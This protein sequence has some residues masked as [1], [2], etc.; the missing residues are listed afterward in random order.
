MARLVAIGAAVLFYL[1]A[2]CAVALADPAG[3]SPGGAAELARLNTEILRHPTDTALNLRY[4][5]LAEALGKPRLA[6]SAYERILVYEPQNAAAIA[7]VSRIRKGLQPNTTKYVL[8]L[9]AK[10]ESN[11]LLLPSSTPVK[12][13]GQFFGDL[14]VRDERRIGGFSWRTLADVDGIAHG[15]DTVLDYA[16]A[17]AMTGP[18]VDLLPGLQVNPAL[19]GAGAYWDSHPFYGEAA[20]SATFETYPSG[21]YE[22]V[23]LRAALRDYDS[24]F[25]PQ[26]DGGYVEAIGKFTI[27]LAVPDTAFSLAPWV[28]WSEIK[29]PIGVVPAFATIEP[30]DYTDVGA[31]IE[32]DYSP[33]DWI[34]LGAN[35]A[36]SERYYRN[37]FATGTTTE[38]RDTTWAPGATIIFPHLVDY[39][40]DLRFDYKYISDRSNDPNF[41]YVDRIVTVTVLRRF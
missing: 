27:P 35:F 20:A 13:E 28:R 22:A 17:G 29:G 19:G 25:V 21:A 3:S 11:P 6:L 5:A 15:T 24:F 37:E 40:T 18:V 1:G 36:A 16:H 33:V 23:M 7:G 4:A 9:G 39:Q 34:V 12:G 41:T 10:Y 31:R 32:A 30:G 26:H 2:Q 14:N 38:R 8:A